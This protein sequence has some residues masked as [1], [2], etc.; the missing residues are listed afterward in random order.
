MFRQRI[1]LLSFVGLGG[2]VS[3]MVLLILRF[4]VSHIQQPTQSAPGILSINTPTPQQ[5]FD[6]FG[7]LLPTPVVIIEPTP[8]VEPT[9][10]PT[11]TPLSYEGISVAKVETIK[12]GPY[13]K[14]RW[15]PDGK[16]RW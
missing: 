7:S 5:V 8:T 3:L 9:P 15:S 11:S 6:Q 13:L 4:S 14:I 16:K 2:I 1:R 12:T 10:E